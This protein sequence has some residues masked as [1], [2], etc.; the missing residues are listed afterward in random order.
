MTCT[1]GRLAAFARMDDQ[2]SV[3]RD[4]YRYEHEE[5]GNAE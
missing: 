1:G 5:C 3:P 4:V 2:L